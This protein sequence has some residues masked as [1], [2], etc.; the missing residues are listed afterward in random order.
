VKRLQ[1][2]LAGALVELDKDELAEQVLQ[3]ACDLKDAGVQ[4][5]H[6]AR[7]TLNI[8]DYEACLLHANMAL[9]TLRH[10]SHR[11]KTC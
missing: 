4:A 3:L 6:H 5:F 8:R 10:Q 9:R 2:A 1:V 7:L 11:T